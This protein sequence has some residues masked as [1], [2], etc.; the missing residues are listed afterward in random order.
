MLAGYP[1]DP[2]ISQSA[3]IATL[4]P[5][6]FFA[7][8]GP[9][10][11]HNL[12]H[13]NVPAYL[14]QCYCIKIEY[15]SLCGTCV[16][17]YG[18]NRNNLSDGVRQ[19]LQ[20][21]AEPH[22]AHYGVAP[23]APSE[24]YIPLQGVSVAVAD[25]HAALK[26]AAVIASTLPDNYLL[27][28]IPVRKEA[29]S[30]SSIEG[31][32]STLDELLLVEEENTSENDATH[33][34]RDYALALETVLPR[35]RELG[36]AIFDIDLIRNLHAATMNSD[37]VYRD[38]KGQFRSRVVWIGGG[39]I[40]QSTYNP[41]PPQ[42][43]DSCMEDHIRYLHGDGMQVMNQ[44]FITRMAVAHAHFE[45]VHP[46]RDGNGRVGR[47]LLPVMMAAEGHEPVYLSSFIE[48]NKQ[49]YYDGLK[50]AQQRLDYSPLVV[51]MANA[52]K[53]SVY[54][55]KRL[56]SDL[57][58]LRDGWMR[59]D[60]WRAGS[61]AVRALDILHEYPVLTVGRLASLLDVSFQSASTAMKTLVDT[62]ILL[63]KTG[64]A[65]NRIFTAPEAVAL[66]NRPF[67]E[68]EPSGYSL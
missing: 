60:K 53:E 67:G 28:R 46:F 25:A 56:R 19:T 36:S 48:E 30:S 47:L 43:V 62:G 45:G 8:Q 4:L 10:A 49:R 29:L 61:T 34:V 15:G 7:V 32:N 11:G 17:G 6:N 16:K 37:A 63:E 38:P 2:E 23:L 66:L 24:D 64:Y 58:E 20:R 3:L 22:D 35:A 9:G 12:E 55:L 27:T 14:I 39:D 51:F 26:E 54:E 13:G 65:R 44:D 31:T 59:R 68:Y 40:S 42:F 33:Q 57:A 52:I 18:M 5:T 50:A 21:F 1:T 41:P